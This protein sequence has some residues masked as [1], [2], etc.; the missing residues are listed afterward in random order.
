MHLK[1][2]EHRNMNVLSPEYRRLNMLYALIVLM[3]TIFVYLT[4]LNVT[5]FTHY[6]IATVDAIGALSSLYCYYLLRVKDNLKLCSW[7]VSVMMT[8]LL[9]LF[10]YLGKG[11]NYG[12]AWIMIPPLINYFF[13]GVKNGTRMSVFTYALFLAVIYRNVSVSPDDELSITAL[14]NAVYVMVIG[15]LIIRYYEKSR[16]DAARLLEQ[17]NTELERLSSTDKLTG[18]YNRKKLDDILSTASRHAKH[19]KP[20]SI[21]L[22]D[23]DHFKRINDTHGHLFGDKVLTHIA[24]LFYQHTRGYHTGRWGGE[25]FLVVM[26][27]TSQEQAIKVAQRLQQQLINEPICEPPVTFSCGIASTADIIAPEQLVAQA[28]KQLYKAKHS[29]RNCIYAADETVGKK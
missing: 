7:I 13:L 4:I 26:P 6:P 28:D 25:E 17:Q 24:H 18:L 29:G 12:V 15:L 23:V 2:E 14:L 8:L 19:D 22:C 21:M 3:F 10:L 27:N 1:R 9:S 11:N 20:L 5:V 16:D